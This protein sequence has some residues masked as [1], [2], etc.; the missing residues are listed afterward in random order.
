MS[1]CECR[2]IAKD[3][4]GIVTFTRV[5]VV[6]CPLHEAAS[7]LLKVAEGAYGW[8]VSL[9]LESR[10]DNSWLQPLREAIV[11]ARGGRGGGHGWTHPIC[12]PCWYNMGR[13]APIRVIDA[14]NEVCCM[15]GRFTNAGIYY[16]SDP[17]RMPCKGESNG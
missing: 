13:E 12:G 11:S 5:E 6:Y 14:G 7:K 1:D 17:S 10:P 2:V 15:C 4:P 8:L 3:L 16:R 9:P